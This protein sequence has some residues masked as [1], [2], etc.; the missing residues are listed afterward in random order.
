MT[1]QNYGSFGFNT[2]DGLIVS[3]QL[4]ETGAATKDCTV[5]WWLYIPSCME[6]CMF[7][8]ACIALVP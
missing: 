4:Q 7:F 2:V 1:K 8:C 6:V 5:A 3:M